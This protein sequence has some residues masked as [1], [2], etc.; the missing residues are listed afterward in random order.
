M[1]TL[2]DVLKEIS[3]FDSSKAMQAT[4]IPVKVIKDN[5]VI[6]VIFLQNKYGLISMNLLVKENCL[7]L[8][9]ITPV[10]K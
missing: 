9:N 2:D 10:F 7:K 5:K 4:D 8:A 3:M 6:T 1:I